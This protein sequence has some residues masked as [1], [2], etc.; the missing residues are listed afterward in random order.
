MPIPTFTPS[1]SALEAAVNA[2]PGAA[3]PHFVLA[4][5]YLT[6]GNSEAAIGQYQEVVKLQPGDKLSAGLVVALTPKPAGT[7][8]PTT[9]VATVAAT[10][11]AG[12]GP[13]P[14]AGAP[15]APAND[16]PPASS[17]PSADGSRARRERDPHRL[18][19]QS[20]ARCRDRVDTQAREQ[21]QLERDPGRQNPGVRWRFHLWRNDVDARS[22]GR[23]RDGR[24]TDL[25]RSEPLRV[26]DRRRTADRSWSELRRVEDFAEFGGPD[27]VA[28]RLSRVAWSKRAHDRPLS[29]A[30]TLSGPSLSAQDCAVPILPPAAENAPISRFRPRS[31]IRDA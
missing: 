13:A 27:L 19:S 16:T 28:A 22:I 18:E 20:P 14:I 5:H 6:Q 23:P 4:Y 7:V 11:D 31:C 30:P 17:H 10:P 8:A 26:Q 12:A 2:N 25:V 3:P 21:V 9:T 15:V 29:T 1:N 24:Q